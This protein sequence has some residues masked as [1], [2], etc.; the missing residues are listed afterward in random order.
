MA[1][2]DKYI[3]SKLF[4]AIPELRVDEALLSVLSKQGLVT[5]DDLKAA[6]FVLGISKSYG[7]LAA[8]MRDK[9]VIQRIMLVAPEIMSV[10]M[11]D[12]LRGWGL[13]SPALGNSLRIGLRA[14][15]V[16]VPGKLSDVVELDRWL[17]LG[18]SVL[19]FHTINL[20]RNID[21]AK[22]NLLRKNIAADSSLD[23]DEKKAARAALRDVESLSILRAN[24]MRALLSAGRLS[25]E[26]IAAIKDATTVWGVLT[27]FAETVLSD[28]L[29]RDAIRAG[30]ISQKD[31]DLISAL[32]KLGLNVWKKGV[33][34]IDYDA[35]QA[36]FLLLSEGI[37]SP[38]MINALILLNVIPPE[39]GLLLNAAARGIRSITRGELS[40]YMKGVRI[41]VV[42][43]ESPIKTYARI[44][45]ATD[46]EILKL[47]A[48]A[49]QEARK[50]AERLASTEKFGRLT[51]A[52][53][54]RLISD[55]LNRQMHALWE[56]VGHL[57]VFGEKEAARAAISSMDFLEGN[58]WS[59]VSTKDLEFRRM[60]QRE[61]ENGID[62]FV[63]RRENLLE[64]SKRV[65]KN[66]ALSKDLLSRRINIGLLRG[67]S[68][69]ELATSVT[70]LI[71]PGAPGGV[72]YN[73]MRLARTEINNAFHFST[74]RNT[75]EMPWV[76][77]YQWNLSGSH[78]HIDICN[79]MAQ[80]NHDGI[81]RGVYKKAN[82]PPKPHPQC[83]CY[84]TTVTASPGEFENAFEKGNYAPYLR[85]TAKNGAFPEVSSW[86]SVYNDQAKTVAGFGAT[87][88]GTYAVK[89][90]GQ[91]AISQILS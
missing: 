27:I 90:L 42:P 52:A 80:A 72:S 48:E 91:A 8:S 87:V 22:I 71:N 89:K 13:I 82:V 55:A 10:P 9:T 61:A 62:A 25:A 56:G 1:G 75:R 3:L 66:E 21:E 17:A 78:P 83:F 32:S 11:I 77:G 4:I 2:F 23:K 12:L 37:L 45:G 79:T 5:A 88:L 36:R 24:R 86:H 44:T 70:S 69:K 54:Q 7:E 28:R 60:L 67:L 33:K 51:R 74:I 14:G 18:S 29:L 26:A 40:K 31:Y 6:E 53:Q 85:S 46:R 57:T 68:P 39:M 81:G 34:S 43:G 30:A 41:R 63:S 64:F 49:S 50:E 16:L 59:H 35:I 20:L 38:E 15:K 58:L 84:L 65:Y 73:A 76:K 19:S 47:L